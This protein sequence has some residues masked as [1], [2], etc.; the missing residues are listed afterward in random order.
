MA[1]QALKMWS[2]LALAA[3]CMLVAP[4][5]A[6]GFHGI[7]VYNLAPAFTWFVSHVFSMKLIG[8]PCAPCCLAATCC[9]LRQAG[10]RS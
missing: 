8:I 2:A 3:L 10:I 4:A 7:D 6:A 5:A 1:A 9:G